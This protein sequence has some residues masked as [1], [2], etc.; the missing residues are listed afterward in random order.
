M[1]SIK[2][3]LILACAVA[4]AVAAPS[5]FATNGY[6]PHGIGT[7]AKAM[8]GV[9]IA[10]PQG[11]MAAAS[12]PAAQMYVGNK[13][14]FG[15][16]WFRPFR[17]ATALNAAGDGIYTASQSNDYYMPEFGYATPIGSSSS[18][19][20]VVHGAGLGTDYGRLWNTTG[21][22]TNLFSLLKQMTIAPTFATKMGNHSFGVSLNIVK[23]NLDFR[24][25]QGF[26]N[27]NSSASPGNVTDRGE[28]NA[29]GIGAKLGWIGEL[30]PAFSMG[31]TLQ[32]QTSM[33]KFGKYKGLLAE[34]GK[35]DVPAQYGLGLSFKASPA[36]VVGF[37]V[38][39]IKWGSV[40]S[41]A[42]DTPAAAAA[43]LVAAGAALGN[44]NGAGF[45]WRDQTVYKLGVSHQF[46]KWTLRAGYNYGKTPLQASQTLFNTVMPA[47]TE[48]HY[49][50]GAGWAISNSTDLS[51]AYMYSPSNE[52]KGTGTTASIT[53]SNLKMNQNS[54]AI[55]LNVKM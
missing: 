10:V 31:A 8:G 33:T 28:D 19:G 41:L 55:A 18:L 38:V 17:S 7:D 14:T 15:M 48:T 23:Q 42:N 5:A 51:L 6:M 20:V 40:K 11:G 1:C 9:G 26:D 49:T 39:K 27:A 46:G 45:G 43:G 3:N 2:K 25:F 44:D 53:N 16:D 34:Q 29:S 54:L 37:D 52:L 24:G 4:A 22:T 30:T 47:V 13:L 35:L 21:G 50:L 32:P 12:N 36:T